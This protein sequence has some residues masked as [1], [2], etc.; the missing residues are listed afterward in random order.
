MPTKTQKKPSYAT[1]IRKIEKLSVKQGDLESFIE[2]RQRMND[3]P[4]ELAKAEVK[5]GEVT[6]E[7]KELVQDTLGDFLDDLRLAL[8]GNYDLDVDDL[9][10]DIVNKS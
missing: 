2:M 3:A 5:L 8:D 9:L 6:G 7:L 1:R 10:F 4:V